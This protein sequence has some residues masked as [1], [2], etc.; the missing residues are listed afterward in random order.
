MNWTR[1]ESGCGRVEILSQNLPGGTEENLS[2]ESR[3]PNKEQSLELYCCIN[4]A[5]DNR[6]SIY[7]R[8]K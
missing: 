8:V 6:G 3:D 1:F 5:L 2:Q 4:L 7:S